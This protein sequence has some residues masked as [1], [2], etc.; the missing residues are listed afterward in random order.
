M[1][2]LKK[3]VDYE[4]ADILLKVLGHENGRAIL[5]STDGPLEF[6]Y[7]VDWENAYPDGTYALP[8]DGETLWMIPLP[9]ARRIMDLYQGRAED[10]RKQN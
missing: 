6:F 8:E 4:S 5:V 1:I 3:P 10:A 2:L 9:E 7:I